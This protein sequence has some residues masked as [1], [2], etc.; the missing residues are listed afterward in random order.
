MVFPALRQNQQSSIYGIKRNLGGINMTTNKMIYTIEEVGEILG[1]HKEDVLCLIESNDLPVVGS[2]KNLIKKIDLEM[3]MGNHTIPIDKVRD[4]R[5]NIMQDYEVYDISDE[6]WNIMH[7]EETKV[8][9]PYFNKNR[10]KWCIA[11]SLGKTE[12]GKRKRKII[13]AD[14]RDGVWKAYQEYIVTQT[15]IDPIPDNSLSVLDG[16]A[17]K[18]GI[19]TYSCK[20]DILFE[21]HYKKFLDGLK[22]GIESKTYHSY[23]GI[24][25][26]IIQGL[27]HFKMYEINQ[28]IIENFMEE[29]RNK[30]YARGNNKEPNTYLSQSYLQKVHSLLCRFIKSCSNPSNELY[31]MML[32]FSSSIKKPKSKAI[33][34]KEVETPKYGASEAKSKDVRVDDMIEFWI[35]SFIEKGVSLSEVLALNVEDPFCFLL[36]FYCLIHNFFYVCNRFNNSSDMDSNLSR[37]I[38][39]LPCF[40]ALFLQI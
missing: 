18:N 4:E 24:S 39:L 40:M 9:T 1:I 13:V 31:I 33:A 6:E 35:I 11:L 20:Q 7:K 16:I 37:L 25:K 22:N 10:R 17:Q 5:S 32:D 14:T 26:C 23:I 12:E 19:K 3:F 38:L 21:N 34:K 2:R 27:G 30:K 29:I 36:I 8:H 28:Q 15:E